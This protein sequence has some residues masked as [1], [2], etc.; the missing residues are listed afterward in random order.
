MHFRID[1]HIEAINDIQQA[2]D[3]YNEQQSGLG[4]RFHSAVKQTFKELSV[5][6][7]FQVRYDNVRC[8][9]TRKFPYLIHFVVDEKEKTVT[10]YRLKHTSM[11]PE[12]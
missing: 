2:I 6:P 9:L 8:R 12:K 5:N 10:I 1:I 11:K 4:K 3:Y 7:F